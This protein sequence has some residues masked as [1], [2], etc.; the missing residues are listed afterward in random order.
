MPKST[1]E[2]LASTSPFFFLGIIRKFRFD[3]KSSIQSQNN[4]YLIKGKH[5]SSFFF[6]CF[7]PLFLLLTLFFVLKLSQS[8]FFCLINFY[9][10]SLSVFL[11]SLPSVFPLLSF[12]FTSISSS[13]SVLPCFHFNFSI[14]FIFV[15]R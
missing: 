11:I 15:Y 1:I 4:S 13:V 3:N 2:F 6:I 10:F 12:S 9:S 14:C 7:I 5:F 8:F